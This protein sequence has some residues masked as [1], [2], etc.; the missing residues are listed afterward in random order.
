MI[1][2]S[3]LGMRT[4][5][6]LSNFPKYTVEGV[7]E[8][9]FVWKQYG[10]TD[11]YSVRDFKHRPPITYRPNLPCSIQLIAIDHFPPSLFFY[12]QEKHPNPLNMLKSNF[13]GK[14]GLSTE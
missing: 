14:N 9:S 8:Y 10:R 1:R 11:G 12:A 7:N 5:G 4:K 13:Q 3:Q 6:P 2:W